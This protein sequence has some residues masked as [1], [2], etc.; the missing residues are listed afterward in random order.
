MSIR[1]K[2]D[3]GLRKVVTLARVQLL[4]YALFAL[5]MMVLLLQEVF[6]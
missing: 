6:F 5:S 2:E 3:H 1:E 4:T